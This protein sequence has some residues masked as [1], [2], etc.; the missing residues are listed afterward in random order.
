LTGV[1]ACEGNGPNNVSYHGTVEILRHESTY[2]VRW[3][4][5]S[6]EE[7]LGIGVLNGDVLAVSYFGGA[8]GVVVYRVEQNAQGPRLV[9]QWTV[10][11]AAGQVFVETLTRLTADAGEVVLPKPRTRPRPVQGGRSV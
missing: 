5:S 7:Y 1:Y 6:A 8:P 11:E 3:S 9:G 2:Q 10:V 4:I